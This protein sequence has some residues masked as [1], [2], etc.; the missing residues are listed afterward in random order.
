MTNKIGIKE[1]IEQA[2][3]IEIMGEAVYRKLEQMFKQEGLKNLFKMLADEELEHYQFFLKMKEDLS[4]QA[5]AQ[6]LTLMEVI[7]GSKILDDKI[8][9]RSEIIQKL[10]HAHSPYEILNSS[11]EVELEVIHYYT[12]LQHFMPSKE[13][14]LL[15]PIINSEKG[16]VKALIQER[17]KYKKTI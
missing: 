17:E 4:G 16:H 15:S 10:T 3:K 1:I 9:N 5:Y 6:N 8:F 13:Q 12:H 11:V 2:I 14:D 7:S